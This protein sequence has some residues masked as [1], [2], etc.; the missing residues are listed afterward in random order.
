[1]SQTLTDIAR[2]ISAGIAVKNKKTTEV[3]VVQQTPK[4]QLIY[5]FNGTGK[6]R[7]SREFKKLIA[8]KNPEGEETEDTRSKVIY[9][10]AFTEDLFYWDN[11][12]DLDV[13]RK[14]KIHPNNYTE[15]VLQEQGQDRNAITHFQ[16][17]T[18]DKLT[19][20]FNEEYAVKDERGKEL[21][22]KDG[23]V[24][25]V[26]A[27]SEVTFSFERGNKELSEHV[28]ISKG[29][30]SCFIWSIFYS[31]IEQ[32]IDVLNVPEPEERETD[33]YDKLEY[34]FIDDPVSSLDENHLIELAV[35]VAELIKSSE[36][37]NGQ[38]L[39][40]IVTTHNPLFYNILC[41][42][43]NGLK[44]NQ[45]QK[46]RLVKHEDGTLTL[47]NQANDSPFSYHLFLKSELEKARDTGDI[48]KYHFN[49]LRNI[50]EKT[51]T[52]VGANRWENLLPEDDSGQP[53]PYMKR[54][55]NLSSHSKQSG[56]EVA[57][58][59]EEDKRVFKF[60]VQKLDQM[61][62]LKMP[63]K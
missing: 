15:W 57:D 28:K 12:L 59:D 61:Y 47:E 55:L 21:I 31:L 54:I 26:P 40:F 18:N 45:F 41:N 44:K 27:F 3:E 10:N 6:T 51:S 13:E 9:Y 16:R 4:L 42:E 1:M 30:E 63:N 24:V 23:K 52:F 25:T 48:R 53:N 17:Y 2:E 62:R 46:Y 14:L 50:L 11:D 60:L 22:G 43:F 49:F 39:K 32:V 19:P 35:D 38:G 37:T 20:H 5:A 33:R 56:D 7:L 36:Y 29:E 8:P 58:P 34:I